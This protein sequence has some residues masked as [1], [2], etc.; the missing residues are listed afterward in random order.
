MILYHKKQKDIIN[1]IVDDILIGTSKEDVDKIY[2]EGISSLN[3]QLLKRS[4]R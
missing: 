4:K 3:N 2:E 1:K